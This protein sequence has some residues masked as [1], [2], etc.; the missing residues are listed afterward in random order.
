VEPS[1][2]LP[3]SSIGIG[4]TARRDLIE[5]ILLLGLLLAGGVSWLIYVFGDSQTAYLGAVV[6]SVLLALRL[7]SVR[8]QMVLLL[9]VGEVAL[10]GTEA[11][12]SLAAGH[13]LIGTF[14]LIDLTVAAALVGLAISSLWM[15]DRFPSGAWPRPRELLTPGA[16]LAIVAISYMIA[17]GV[18][19]G[20]RADEIT[21][22]DLRV[23]G[24][25]IGMWL[26]ARSC[27][28]GV[29]R[30]LPSAFV[31]LGPFLS[32][33]ALAIAVS[34]IWVVGTY[35]RLQA[36]TSS[37]SGQTR[38]ILIGGDTV[39]ILI[40][41]VTAFALSY[42]KTR[43]RRLALWFCGLA[44]LVGLVLSG[45]RTGIIVAGIL[46]L[47]VVLVRFSASE[48][49]QRFS[50]AVA[51]VVAIAVL[52]VGIGLFATGTASRFA[53][54][55]RP[56]VG[57]NF[58]VDEIHSFLRLP[59]RDILVGQGIGGRFLSKDTNGHPVVSG[60]AHVFPI[61]VMLKAGVAGLLIVAV[62]VA[63]ILRS[64]FRGLRRPY[65]TR[66]EAAFSLIIIGGLLLMSLT[67]DRI[68]IPEGAVLFG[69]AV[70]LLGRSVSTSAW[71]RFTHFYG[72][73]SAAFSL[74]KGSVVG[75][76]AKARMDIRS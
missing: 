69:L 39:L 11:N 56:H 10:L 59:K 33:K 70:G 52:L 14:R 32:A 67:I 61:W 47:G 60:W 20:P 6:A 16:I 68:A 3:A 45:T 72:Y 13:S 36:S 76:S 74:V 23:L 24:L 22:T 5:S 58:R 17:L 40:P 42:V 37:V 49:I 63:L 27:A 64:G 65:P 44:S 4:A 8:S 31:G 1:A 35:D 9:L 28:F 7:G 71:M 50:P 38:V 15:R 57:L 26:L 34:G 12:G 53:T 48:L 62:A 41:P 21:K 19:H 73:P 54:P 18:L 2:S 29:L 30:D 66:G 75:S 51:S 25:A 43:A 55:D 46:V